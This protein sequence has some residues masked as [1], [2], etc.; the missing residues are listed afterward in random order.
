M[1]K[2]AEGSIY[3]ISGTYFKSC[4]ILSLKFLFL[5]NQNTTISVPA[6]LAIIESKENLND[7]RFISAVTGYLIF[8][9]LSMI[10]MIN[11]THSSNFQ[12]VSET[13]FL[14]NKISFLLINIYHINPRFKFDVLKK[15]VK[16]N[17]KELEKYLM[18]IADYNE[19]TKNYELKE[20]FKDK[21]DLFILPQ[22]SSFF[23][24]FYDR[25]NSFADHYKEFSVLLGNIPEPLIK[26]RTELLYEKLCT[27]GLMEAVC[28]LFTDELSDSKLEKK[29]SL[30]LILK[31]IS[32][33]LDMSALKK[34]F[35]FFINW[36]PK[37]I[38]SAKKLLE[39]QEVKEVHSTLDFLLIKLQKINEKEKFEG[40]NQKNSKDLKSKQLEKKEKIL[41]E[42]LLKQ[43]KFMDKNFESEAV[44]HSQ[45]EIGEKSKKVDDLIC[46]ICLQSS[47]KESEPL[48]YTCFIGKDKIHDLFQSQN[49]NKSSSVSF[50]LSSCGHLIHGKCY[51]ENLKFQKENE[52]F[53]VNSEFLC[54][55]CKSLSNLLVPLVKDT[56][57]QNKDKKAFFILKSQS[58]QHQSLSLM[59]DEIFKSL[60]NFEQKG[61]FKTFQIKK[62][63]ES[64][65]KT[66]FDNLMIATCFEIESQDNFACLR[67]LN[68]MLV[69]T[70]ETIHMKNLTTYFLN[71]RVL[72]SNLLELF[73][74][75]MSCSENYKENWMKYK[76]MYTEDIKDFYKLFDT[77]NF[78][79]TNDA[80]IHLILINILLKT[81]VIFSFDENLR[82]KI[83]KNIIKTFLTQIFI[84]TTIA[85]SEPSCFTLTF[86]KI[87]E[88]FENPDLKTK[89]MG[90]LSP[91][92]F[93]ILGMLMTFY[94]LDEKRQVLVESFLNSDHDIEN[95]KIFKRFE[96]LLAP[97]ANYLK[98]F[99]D[100][101]ENCNVISQENIVCFKQNFLK[102]NRYEI[103]WINSVT[104]YEDFAK[105]FMSKTC[106]VCLYYPRTPKSDLY[107]CLLCSKVFCNGICNE[108][109]RATGNLT[110]H[111]KDVHEGCA[112]YLNLL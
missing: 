80:N 26:E 49:K 54:P 110:T 9:D 81:F 93:I 13:F 67:F 97:D 35:T 27:N 16:I 20:F 14:K 102:S 38:E 45:K 57:D 99:L 33:L 12:T 24:E 85:L 112:V 15:I 59:R 73:L 2:Q 76:E 47:T 32:F 106:E 64:H 60:S 55:Y 6:I 101:I 94:Q 95:T 44:V 50:Y 43:K 63:F 8:D 88:Y 68:E 3:S 86:Q 42:F 7:F 72:G 1:I 111:A 100:E 105:M 23:A 11:R 71:S 52:M 17:E 92:Y 98:Q 48:S 69:S 46:S 90:F 10:N 107:L 87:L 96:S 41:A 84:V 56:K 61:E 19:K 75:Y 40:D 53:V 58:L 78:I 21:F 31:I 103:S 82:F 37:L 5:M 51:S 29:G 104:T 25:I 28:Q 70:F 18:D 66:F 91:Y 77:N 79:I 108:V 39:N 4:D 89:V 109:A 22:T 74:Y 34:H 30:R 83:L 62:E 65:F 36:G